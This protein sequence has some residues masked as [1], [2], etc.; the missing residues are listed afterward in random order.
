MD[1]VTLSSVLL[2]PLILVFFGAFVYGVAFSN[3]IRDH[4]LPRYRWVGVG[5]LALAAVLGAMTVWKLFEPGNGAFYR[6]FIGNQRK[7]VAAHYASLILPLLLVG[8]VF[9]AEAW[10]KRY[11]NEMA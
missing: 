10:F 9:A 8:G 5:L 3:G 11:R 4:T 1:S 7:L 6:A 2:L